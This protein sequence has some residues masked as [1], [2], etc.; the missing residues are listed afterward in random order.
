MLD[1]LIGKKVTISDPYFLQFFYPRFSIVFDLNQPIDYSKGVIYT[2]LISE[3]IHQRLTWLTRGLFIIV[4]QY[5]DITLETPKDFINAFLP[6]YSDKADKYLDYP[7]DEFIPVLK[8][9]WII[10]RRIIYYKEANQGVFSLYRAMTSSKTEL[11]NAYFSL[12]EVM[13]IHKIASCVFSF[14]QRV[15]IQNYDGAGSEYKISINKAYLK[16]GK[17]IKQAVQQYV[18]STQS[19]EVAL[20]FLLDTLNG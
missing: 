10:Q 8:Q 13:P 7:M 16:F 9:Y 5:G 6:M 3:S 2:G 15:Q 4:S 20:F 14:L 18:K 19:P 12:L 11:Y 17:K 1:T